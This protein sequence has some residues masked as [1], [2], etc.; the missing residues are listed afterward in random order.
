MVKDLA[1]L[2][3][4]LGSNPWPWQLL[5]AVGTAK[6]QTKTKKEFLLWHDGISGV[7]GA[8]GRRFNPQPKDLVL[9]QLWHQSHLQLRSDPWPGDSICCRVAKKEKQTKKKGNET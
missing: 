4:W 8:L 3:L 1:P 7:S 6:T 2:L 9:P 5:H